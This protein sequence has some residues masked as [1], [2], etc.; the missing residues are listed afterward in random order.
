MNGWMDGND[1][2]QKG[3]FYTKDIVFEYLI[4]GIF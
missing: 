2:D 1:L 4:W 3:D